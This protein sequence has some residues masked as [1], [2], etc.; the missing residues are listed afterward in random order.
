MMALNDR[1]KH[2][3]ACPKCRAVGRHQ[4]TCEQA[5]LLPTY[6]II[7]N[8]Q[9]LQ[10]LLD[11]ETY[12]NESDETGLVF[13]S[14]R[15]PSFRFGRA[16]VN[17]D[18]GFT[19][20][21]LP[22]E[23]ERLLNPR[24]TNDIDTNRPFGTSAQDD[25]NQ[26]FVS[27]RSRDRVRYPSRE[28][29]T[30]RRSNSDDRRNGRRSHS[31]D[32]EME[33]R[34]QARRESIGFRFG[35]GLGT[36]LNTPSHTPV[37]PTDASMSAEERNE[38]QLLQMRHDAK[39]QA[40]VAKVL[41]TDIPEFDGDKENFLTWIEKV[42]AARPYQDP[43]LFRKIVIQKLG[44]VPTDYVRG[45]GERA[46][47]LDG[48]LNA[49]NR[50]Y[51]ILANRSFTTTKLLKTAQG[52]RTFA[53]YNTAYSKYLMALGKGNNTYDPMIIAKYCD[54]V[55]DI[56][57][58]RR[59]YGLIRKNDEKGVVTTLDDLMRVSKRMEEI[60]DQ[61]EEEA[62]NKRGI[63]EE[64]DEEIPIKM[65]RVGAARKTFKNPT[66]GHGACEASTSDNPPAS[67]PNKTPKGNNN[68]D[69]YCPIHE[70]AG[71]D[72]A[73]CRMKDSN[74]CKYCKQSIT[75]GSYVQHLTK[76]GECKAKRCHNC[77]KRGHL[78]KDCRVRNGN[79][80]NKG[81]KGNGKNNTQQK[82]KNPK[83]NKNNNGGS[84]NQAKPDINTRL[85]RH[86]NVGTAADGEEVD[87]QGIEDARLILKS[88]SSD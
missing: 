11:S 9:I 78:K 26:G 61:I 33:P 37:F 67:T 71:H 72:F 74:Y 27:H 57:V 19:W 56:H 13:R 84:N 12:N 51:N 25:F 35:D 16:L 66:Q 4:S 22:P 77:N 69:S 6:A 59:L 50:E 39:Q 1:A 63:E 65:A 75:P 8:D 52:S 7:E 68:K 58:K 54:G 81:G 86:A 17:G 2:A 34:N 45:L 44:T 79:T 83:N 14:S 41:M 3:V 48:L 70:T 18:L 23:A 43:V 21:L 24:D 46:Q 20:H 38:R 80:P 30:S 10:V 36:F 82:D 31:E 88:E 76:P 73:D 5:S 42:E 64:Q 49:L 28:G 53:E 55:R 15:L 29:R 40:T 87:H 47:T 62:K 60:D 32:R 85:M